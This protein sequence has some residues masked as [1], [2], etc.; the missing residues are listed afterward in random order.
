MFIFVTDIGNMALSRSFAITTIFYFIC[1]L[2]SKSRDSARLQIKPTK[3]LLILYFIFLALFALT[4]V[5]LF[6]KAPRPLWFFILLVFTYI[7]S[8]FT[9]TAFRSWSLTL[10][11]NLINVVVVSI[12]IYTSL[13]T[14]TSFGT[15][16]F[17]VGDA[18]ILRDG[19]FDRAYPYEPY[20]W[21]FLIRQCYSL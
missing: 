18:V 15:D 21:L 5:L 19:S 17:N 2:F 14:F 3:L 6:A 16:G 13:G 7:T 4:P 1:L 12:L 10:V 20:F 11:A 9:A 8:Y